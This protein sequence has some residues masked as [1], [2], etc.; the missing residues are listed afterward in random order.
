MES[1][2]EYHL[3]NPSVFDIDNFNG[4]FEG[5]IVGKIIGK[6]LIIYPCTGKRL[7]VSFGIRVGIYLSL[8]N[9]LSWKV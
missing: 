5:K 3:D 7:S 6:Q 8:L 2:F 1:I 4:E 9:E